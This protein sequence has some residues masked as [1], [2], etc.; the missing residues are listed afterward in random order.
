[1][2]PLLLSGFD[3]QINPKH[4]YSA[5]QQG[6][7]KCMEPKLPETEPEKRRQDGRD[8]HEGQ[9]EIKGLKSIEADLGVSA[10]LLGRQKN[11]G[12][13]Y[14][15][16]GN[17]T[18]HGGGAIAKSIKWIDVDRRRNRALRLCETANV[19]E[20]RLR[21]DLG[22]AVGTV[23]QDNSRNLSIANYVLRNGLVP[24]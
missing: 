21:A 4:E 22:S 13:D 19:A 15:E 10:V 17:V 3:Q 6:D 14:T 9:E 20:R 16:H 2:H 7:K 5:F 12:R 23:W 8:N 18:Q 24:C 11:D 1:V